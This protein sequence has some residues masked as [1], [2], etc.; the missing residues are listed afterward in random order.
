MAS[1]VAWEA[2]VAHGARMSWTGLLRSGDEFPPTRRSRRVVLSALSG[3]PLERL[4]GSWSD[5]YARFTLNLSSPNV[6]VR[7]VAPDEADRSGIQAIVHFVDRADMIRTDGRGVADSDGWPRS[8]WRAFLSRAD[9]LPGDS[10]AEKLRT[11]LESALDGDLPAVASWRA[12]VGERPDARAGVDALGWIPVPVRLEGAATVGHAV[13][14]WSSGG[15]RFPSLTAAL[16]A[17]APRGSEVD[18]AKQATYYLECQLARLHG[19]EFGHHDAV[20]DSTFEASESY[21]AVA[22]MLLDRERRYLNDP[23]RGA[24]DRFG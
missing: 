23:R 20:T 16:R 4:Y 3:P 19:V 9:S 11:Y 17:D 22:P 7:T 21:R 24:L 8:L 14:S 13:L 1:D 15:L 18:E 2:V 12:G 6:R 10:L 5:R